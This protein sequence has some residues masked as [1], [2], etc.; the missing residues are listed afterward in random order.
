MQNHIMYVL[1]LFHIY[2][3]LKIG[4]PKMMFHVGFIGF[5]LKPTKTEINN[6]TQ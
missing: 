4:A 6:K 5:S 3:C 2:G 1:K